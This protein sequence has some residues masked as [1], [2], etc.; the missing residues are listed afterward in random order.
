M[1]GTLAFV[2]SSSGAGMT[3][4]GLSYIRCEVFFTC[5]VIMMLVESRVAELS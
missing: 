2:Y 5:L 4:C 1:C 3:L